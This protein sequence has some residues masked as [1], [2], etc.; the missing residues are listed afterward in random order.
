MSSKIHPSAI[1]SPNAEIGDGVEI[2]PNCIVEKEV[3]IGD[4][5]VLQS[6]VFIDR[7]TYIGK[8]NFIGHGAVLGTPP[9]DKK[10]DEDSETS[11]EIGDD[12]IFREYATVN[13][14]TG[15]G[16]KTVIGSRC[17]L[18]TQSHVGHNCVIGNEVILSNVATL[19][20]HVEVDDWAILGG[21]IAI[22]QFT[23]LG[24]GTYM[25]GFSAI[26][27][28]LPPFFRAAGN[29]GGPA[30][31]NRVGMERRGL[32][33]ESVRAVHDSY[34]ILYRQKLT[35]DEA[36]GKMLELYG[37]VEEVQTIVDFMQATKNGIL[38]PRSDRG[39]A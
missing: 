22:H 5:C 38:R 19:A 13:R 32:T 21:V 7:H 2:G 12:N 17:L 1:V 37:E 26:R 15:T 28:D 4:G 6:Q 24:K 25:G 23:R 18:M 20:G 9:Q 29:P 30:G 36:M 10:F 33:R 3:T 11:L 8:Q 31:I 39:H 27:Q 16:C 34:K 35:L 14:A